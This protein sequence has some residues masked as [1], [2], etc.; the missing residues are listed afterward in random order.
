M[1]YATTSHLYPELLAPLEG[2]TV[3]IYPT[4]R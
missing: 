2:Q 3:T 4:Q 1:A